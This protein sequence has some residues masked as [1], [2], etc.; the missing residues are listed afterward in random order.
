MFGFLLLFFLGE[1]GCL[2]IFSCFFKYF[3]SVIIEVW[4]CGRIL[5][6]CCWIID[7]KLNFKTVSRNAF[8]M[9]FSVINRKG[10]KA[11]L[12][13]GEGG[14]GRGRRDAL[15]D[16]PSLQ[17]VS[18]FSWAPPSCVLPHTTPRGL[19][20][21]DAQLKKAIGKTRCLLQ[22]LIQIPW[23]MSVLKLGC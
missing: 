5:L 20:T 19:Q 12:T 1:G 21:Q 17:L 23:W 8:H 6:L 2:F 15:T 10:K 11:F 4:V 9:I 14:R 22:L 16:L 3:F 13:S 7:I 18:Q